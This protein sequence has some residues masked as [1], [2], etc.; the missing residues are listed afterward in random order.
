MVEMWDKCFMQLSIGAQVE[1]IR[2]E[3]G[4]EEVAEREGGKRHDLSTCID[5]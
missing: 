1:S 2:K 5:V 4:Q 3:E